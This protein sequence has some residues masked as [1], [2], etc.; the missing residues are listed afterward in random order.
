MIETGLTHTSTLVVKKEN[1]AVTMG[2]G[3]LEVLATPAMM[4]L[5]ENAAMLA[6][7]DVLPDGSTTVGS[8]ISSTHLKPTAEGKTVT[9]T[10]TL[11]EAEGRKLTFKVS[12]SDENGVIG[13]GTHIRYIVDSDRFMAKVKR[14]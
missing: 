12:A 1:L 11:T 5:M 9:A 10:A 2:S 7:K 8:Q 6:V 4:A 3:D 13:E 14:Q